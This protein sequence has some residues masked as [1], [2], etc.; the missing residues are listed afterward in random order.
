M[1]GSGQYAQSRAVRLIAVLAVLAAV[2]AAAGI[3]FPFILAILL[4]LIFSPLVERLQAW[5]IPKT[6]TAVVITAAVIGLLA[7][8]ASLLAQPA[9]EWIQSAPQRLADA[10]Q[11]IRTELARYGV[12]RSDA[13]PADPAEG[14]APAEE[15]L[16]LDSE[17]ITSVTGSVLS[18]T[19]SVVGG[20]VIVIVSLFFLLIEGDRIFRR[21]G[22]LIMRHGEE[23]DSVLSDLQHVVARYLGTVTLI[24][25][26][27]GVAI[28]CAQWLF[29]LP[30]PV[31][32]GAM[33]A[34]L[35]FVPFLG[36]L[37]G[38]SVVFVVA[39]L[40]H[41]GWLWVALPPA[42]YLLINSIEGYFVTPMILGRTVQLSPLLIFVV[43]I[44]ASYLG[45]VLGMIVAV[46]LL[47]A[48]KIVCDHVPRL[49]AIARLIG[50]EEPTAASPQPA[51]R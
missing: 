12:G 44:V 51:R 19:G 37:V 17:S 34:L 20:A 25:A 48:A 16:N 23:A 36:A 46:P 30:N 41:D 5:R 15:G 18:T 50:D 7:M 2:R 14:D 3:V 28:G 29:G 38:A 49:T 40:T 6:A 26:V 22:A 45:G 1:A 11:R 4:Y 42:S 27:L 47:V 21:T 43:L 31:L 24:N 32:W 35:N 10:E 8:G 33:A 9:L 39:L 13:A